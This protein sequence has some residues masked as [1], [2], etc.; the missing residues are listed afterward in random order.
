MKFHEPGIT[1]LFLLFLLS[2]LYLSQWAEN[3][4]FFSEVVT[5][6]P[7]ENDLEIPNWADFTLDIQ[8]V[9]IEIEEDPEKEVAE[10]AEESIV[11]TKK[12]NLRHNL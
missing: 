4:P 2:T 7:K 11:E 3:I 1:A 9:D 12:I 8:E 6:L 10:E 5:E